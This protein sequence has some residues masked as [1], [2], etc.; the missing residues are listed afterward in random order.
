MAKVK[1]YAD[2]TEALYERR[3]KFEVSAKDHKLRISYNATVDKVG[4]Y[5][6]SKLPLWFQRKSDT[7]IP[8][9]GQRKGR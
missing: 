5:S 6:E 3:A 8:R 7:E 1:G 9:I 4:R 2:Y